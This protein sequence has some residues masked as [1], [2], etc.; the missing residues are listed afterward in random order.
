MAGW[1]AGWH[2]RRGQAPDRTPEREQS[3]PQ[4]AAALS[5][6]A[7]FVHKI[8]LTRFSA[9]ST[10]SLSA[11]AGGAWVGAAPAPCPAVCDTAPQLPPRCAL[12]L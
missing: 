11:A 6:T 3:Q 10:K 8:T 7:G 2:R 4:S 5:S 9:Q 12:R 1:R